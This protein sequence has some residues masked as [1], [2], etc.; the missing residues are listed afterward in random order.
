[1]LMCF[2]VE[3]YEILFIYCKYL[4]ISENSHSHVELTCQFLVVTFKIFSAIY[5]KNCLLIYN[6]KKK[7]T[8]AVLE[9]SKLSAA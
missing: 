8:S 6:L 5:Y 4:Q 2:L 9:V 7:N 1:M 3:I